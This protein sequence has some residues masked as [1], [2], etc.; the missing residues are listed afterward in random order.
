MIVLH[1][2]MLQHCCLDVRESIKSCSS[3]F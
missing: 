2:L 3:N 1:S